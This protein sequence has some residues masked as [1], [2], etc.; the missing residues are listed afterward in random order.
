MNDISEMW[1]DHKK[2]QQAQHAEW[3]KKNTIALSNSG[4]S[5]KVTGN[6]YLFRTPGKPQVDFYPHTGRWRIVGK[7]ASKKVF[8][9]GGE[10]FINWYI[11]RK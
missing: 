4:L 11:K 7:N 1:S 6:T 5:F 3:H 8:T 2:H 10:A 9:G